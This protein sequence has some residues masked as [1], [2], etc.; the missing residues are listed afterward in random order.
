MGE[1]YGRSYVFPRNPMTLR[2]VHR[3]ALRLFPK[4][5][6]DVAGAAL[7]LLLMLP[8]LIGLSILVLVIDGN[9]VFFVQERAGKGGKPFHIL[10]FRTMIGPA[11]GKSGPKSPS[12][13]KLGGFL[14]KTSLDELPS[15][16]NILLGQ[17]SF[18]GPRPLFVDYLPL[19][20][21]H[22]ALRHDVR[23]GLTGLAQISGRNHLAWKER[24]DLD[25]QYIREQS[26]CFDM[27]IVA[28]TA[29]VAIKGT[30]VNPRNGSAMS[31]LEHGYDQG[32]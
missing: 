13:T 8:F 9:P 5:I 17:M 30:G 19:Y 2:A 11:S 27:W 3:K 21:E 25:V 32:A 15:L 20:S 18:V 24:L 22:H 29:I 14:R 10:K 12:P 16:W 23:P 28:R 26:F 7:L 31:P 4:R 1:S 6:L